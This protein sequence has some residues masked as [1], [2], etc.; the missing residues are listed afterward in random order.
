[1]NF[2]GFTLLFFLSSMARLSSAQSIDPRIQE[3]YGDKTQELVANDPDRLKFLNDILIKRTEI[4]EIP[5][6]SDEDK[7]PKLSSFELLN[8]YNTKLVKDVIFNPDNFNPLK[9]NLNFYS[10]QNDVIIRVDNTNYV[11]IRFHLKR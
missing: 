1:M 5:L 4:K 3:V 8:K 10:M 9:Y 11:L 6:N 7:F 2:K